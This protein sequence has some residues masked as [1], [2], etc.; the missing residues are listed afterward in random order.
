MPWIV[1]L[2]DEAPVAEV[3]NPEDATKSIS[4]PP[5]F[6]FTA[7]DGKNHSTPLN[8][9]PRGVTPRARGR[10]RA[11]SPSKNGVTASKVA[12]PRKSR[13]TKASNAANAANAA[14]A[15]EANASLQAALDNAVSVADSDSIDGEKVT[16]EVGSAVEVNG[17]TETTT[18]NVKVEMPGGSAGF[19]MPEDPEQMIATAKAMVE[20]A[21]R[22]DGQLPSSST[23]SKRKAEELDDDEDETGDKELQPAK[24]ARI[25]EQQ[26]KKERVRTRAL[27]GVAATLVIGFVPA[28]DVNL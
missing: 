14:S 11:T 5:K 3:R 8:A 7:N 20:Q 16:I 2:L 10:P 22:L 1:A 18:T 13:A 24:K 19:P 27:L 15:R 21:R 26:L 12:S 25:L 6:T 28:Q 17:D 23:T 9:T 4:P